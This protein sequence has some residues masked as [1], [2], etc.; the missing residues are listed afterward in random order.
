MIHGL[1]IDVE[2]YYQIVSKDYLDRKIEPTQEVL[3]NTLWLLD[4]LED[5]NIC[6]LSFV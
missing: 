4:I 2:C 3:D 1:S 5:L 6:A